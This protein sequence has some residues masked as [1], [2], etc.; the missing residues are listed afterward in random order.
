[1][2]C[3][4]GG[5]KAEMNDSPTSVLR[6]W[7]PSF[8]KIRGN[9]AQAAQLLFVMAF[10]DRQ[11]ISRDLLQDLVE[12]RQQFDTALGILQGFCLI[13]AESSKDSF[14]M[15]RFVQ[16]ATRF[17]LFSK[18]TDYETLALKLVA[19]K[20][21]QAQHDDKT[22]WRLL[23]PH[24]KVIESYGFQDNENNLLLASLQHNIASH[25]LQAGHYDLAAES[26]E[27]AY[28]TQVRLG[29]ESNLDTLKTAGLLG[30]IRKH[31]ARYEEAD[32][33]HQRVLSK[34]EEALGSTHLD[35]ID[36]WMDL[37]EVLE[38]QGEFAASQELAEKALKVRKNRLG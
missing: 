11:S 35:T 34:K 20:L 14:K 16:L 13:V 29:G 31:Q 27:E 9:Y 1:M 18:R 22:M 32:A 21:D 17:W 12:S 19:A 5:C 38:R 36:T 2:S 6:A 7:A 10:L 3:G 28:S 33:L 26:C 30:V 37:S 25:D 23:I 4:W 24:A 15:H 8:E